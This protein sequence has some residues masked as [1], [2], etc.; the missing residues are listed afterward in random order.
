M[1]SAR[2]PSR[3]PYDGSATP[4]TIGLKPLD[5][6]EWI[7]VDDRLDAFLAEKEQHYATNFDR[8]FRAEEESRPAQAEVLEALAEFLPRRFPGVYR[9]VGSAMEIAG[10]GRRVT[11][12]ATPDMPLVTASRLVQ[13]DLVIMRK[14]ESGWRLSAASLCFPSSWSLAEKFGRALD[15]IHEPVPGFGRGTR[16]AALIERIFDNMKADQPV[17]R[18]N[19]SLQHDEALHHPETKRERDAGADHHGPHMAE[20]ADTF[21]RVER[22]TLRKLP[23][24]GDVLFT[25]RIHLDPMAVL[26]R[27]PDRRRLAASLARQ[28]GGLDRDQL[29]YKGLTAERD[30][31]VAEL[32]ALTA[33]AQAAVS[34]GR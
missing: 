24:S 32:T 7:E 6:D 23:V 34:A 8:V 14:G 2:R 20:I 29:A 28:L 3:T 33:D 17:E 5:P 1:V 4:F 12:D 18:A 26:A 27:H 11:L 13:E 19:W 30:A 16:A 10:T 25:I 15:D 21:I 31:L 22:Q 9:R